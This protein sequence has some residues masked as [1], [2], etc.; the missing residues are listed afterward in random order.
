MPNAH[1]GPIPS[2]DG[3]P[4]LPHDIR[5]H[6]G[7]LLGTTYGLEA[8]ASVPM[9]NRFAKL[10]A[11]L[12]A[13]LDAQ[14]DSDARAFR[15]EFLTMVPRLYNFA[16]SLARNPAQ[17]DDLVQDTLLRGWRSRA[18]YVSG[19]NL[20][21]WL[22]TIMRYAFY[23]QQRKSQREVADSDGGYAE[24]LSTVPEQS[25]HVDLKDA[26]TALSALAPP[27]RQALILVAIES[28]SYEEAAAVMNCR[29]GTVKS[30]V[31]RARAQLAEML[32]YA[33]TE[34][35][36]DGMTLSAMSASS[37]GA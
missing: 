13:A 14:E 27:M 21:A 17:A 18:L 4:A 24:R 20:G 19:T 23:S 11:T 28:L 9:P 29:I 2:I 12:E 34:I 16:M 35:G 5:R 10:M 36:S 33:G 6:L 37:R 25:S 8:E 26:E 32:G 7:R 31:W 1:R 30:R 22:F 3:A 15:A